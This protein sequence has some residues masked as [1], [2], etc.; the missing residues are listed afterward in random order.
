MAGTDIVEIQETQ[1][2]ILNKLKA[3]EERN[4]ST[5]N[6][7][8]T[9]PALY[10]TLVKFRRDS[11]TVAEKSCR[12]T[13]VGIDEQID[14]PATIAFDR[15]A[16]KEVIEC[17][18]DE[19]LLAEWRGRQIDVRRHPPIRNDSHDRRPRIIKI[20]LR[21]Q[22]LRDKLLAYM[23]KGR[24]SLTKHCVHSYARNDYTKEELEY[25][26]ALRKK[27][28]MLNHHEG[29]LIYVVRDL[30]IHKLRN[31]RPLP[32]SPSKISSSG[33]GSGAG[34]NIG[35]QIPKLNS[36]IA[37]LNLP[38]QLDDSEIVVTPTLLGSLPI[39]HGPSTSSEIEQQRTSSRR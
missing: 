12:I 10:S 26:R 9:G 7:D 23:K 32:S 18:G 29:R 37:N 19:D 5:C 21:N 13:W 28:G 38:Q 4:N 33:S 39:T 11:R 25:D 35:T 20:T 27:A 1:N 30:S 3:L 16:V 31:P 36:P 2:S 34:N 22:E 24:L 6:H 8:S 17:S 14:E 15:E